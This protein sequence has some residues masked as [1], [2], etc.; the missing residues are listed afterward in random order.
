MRPRR[1]FIGLVLVV[2]VVAVAAFFVVRRT[3]ATVGPPI[4]LCPGPDEYGY[5]CDTE[6]AFTYIDATNDTFLYEDDGLATLELPFAFTFYGNEYTTV[7]A[8][9][10]GNLQF[11]TENATFDN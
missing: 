3:V 2:V 11:T 10:N 8:S 1:F 9:S 4:A 7:L 5:T 6:A